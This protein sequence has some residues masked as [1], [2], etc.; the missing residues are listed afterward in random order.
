M[1]N[2]TN[3]ND[4]VVT[5]IINREFNNLTDKECEK[6]AMTRLLY[7]CNEQTEQILEMIKEQELIIFE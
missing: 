2:D 3:I 4:P 5:E 1:I 7:D 6:V